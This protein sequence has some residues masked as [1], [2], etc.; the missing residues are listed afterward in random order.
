MIDVSTR[1]RRAILLND[2]ALV[3]RI[4]RNNPTLLQNPDYDDKGNTSLHVAAREGLLEIVEFLIHAGHETPS[5]SLNS[6][7]ETPL[8]LAC[9]HV[10]IPIG[11]LLIYTFPRCVPWP[12]KS[13]MDALMLSSRAGS[14]PLLQPLLTS[15]PPASP[16][17]QDIDGNTALHH[18]SAAGEL[19]ALRLLLH[20]GASPMAQ[21]NYSWTP[22]AY[23]S[24]V[25]AEVYFKQLVGEFEKR[26]VEGLKAEREREKERERQRVGGVRLVTQDLG[27]ERERGS[28][29]LDQMMRGDDGSSA[30]PKPGLEWS[31]VERRAM[32]PTEG[33]EREREREGWPGFGSRGRASSGD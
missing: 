4:V 2:L 17:A 6:D 21:N 19:K 32:T 22:I 27:S 1:F 26:R 9:T 24:T 7:H 25:A 3:K 11:K 13:G 33:R 10:H 31:P 14:L 30:L 16:T 12:N 28:G 15:M 5:I 23:S 20:Y 29:S 8:H 18:A